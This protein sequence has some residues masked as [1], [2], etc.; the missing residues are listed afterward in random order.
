MI[1]ASNASP[2]KVILGN[3]QSCCA[4][5]T[6]WGGTWKTWNVERSWKASCLNHIHKRRYHH[7][8]INHDRNLIISVKSTKKQTLHVCLTQMNPSIQSLGWQTPAPL[9]TPWEQHPQATCTAEHS[10]LKGAWD[11]R[12]IGVNFGIPWTCSLQVGVFQTREA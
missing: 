4:W 7:Q 6:D 12:G 11:S 8:I 10:S 5:P 1:E 9:W 2:A 3:L